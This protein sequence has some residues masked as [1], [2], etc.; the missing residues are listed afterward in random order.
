MLLKGVKNEIEVRVVAEIAQDLGKTEKVPF[1]AK[2]RK[3]SFSEARATQQSL[4]D[5]AM[6]DEEVM[7]QY[8]LGWRDLKDSNGDEIEFSADN[9]AVLMEA[10]EYRKALVDGVLEVLL[11]RD[12]VARKNS[13]R[14][15]TR[16]A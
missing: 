10:T 4:A 2:Y 3:P 11:G 14:P 5:G 16:S 6:T 9:L 13:S 1:R 12:M 15:A 8:L 7:D